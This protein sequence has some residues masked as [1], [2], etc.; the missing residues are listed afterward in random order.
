[1][2][3]IFHF[4][5]SR[6]DYHC[7][8][9]NCNSIVL[10]AICDMDKLFWNVCCLALGETTNGGQ[11]KVSSIYQQLRT[12]SILREPIVV[13]EGLKINPYLLGDAGYA[14]WCYLLHNFKPID[15]NLHKIM[16]DQQMNV[17]RVRIEN[18]FGVL[19]SR[20]RI[21]H[22]IN[23]H[24]DW[25]PGLLVACCVLHNYC[26]LMRL[27]PPQKDPQEDPLCCVRGQMPLLCEGWIVSQ[28]EKAMHVALFKNWMIVYANPIW[29]YSWALWKYRCIRSEI[30]LYWFEIWNTSP[31][32]GL[33]ALTICKIDKKYIQFYFLD[34]KNAKNLAKNPLWI[35]RCIRFEILFNYFEIWNTSA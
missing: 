32:G 7:R 33:L 17:G 31:L 3:T 11:F 25:A 19:K 14:S 21:L 26:Q 15:G 34:E 16:F 22:S 27:P 30:L 12:Q 2:G 1:M 10:Q 5:K 8:R 29:C 9:K 20:W 6:I 4:P 13:V 28:C 23:T 35:Y 18:A 24:V